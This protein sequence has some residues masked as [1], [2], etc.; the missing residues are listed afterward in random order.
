MRER[1]LSIIIGIAIVVMLL[2]V[3]LGI[4]LGFYAVIRPYLPVASLAIIVPIV[5]LLYLIVNFVASLVTIP[6]GV[7]TIRQVFYDAEQKRRIERRRNFADYVEHEIRRLGLLEE[8]RDY[9][10]T[11]LEAEVE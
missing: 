7:V 3:T 4:G 1:R 5:S 9:R 10:F 8:W 2:V 6:A 11:E